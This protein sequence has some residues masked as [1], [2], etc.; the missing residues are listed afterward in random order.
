MKIR[1]ASF[2]TALILLVAPMPAANAA[3]AWDAGHTSMGFL[4]SWL[5]INISNEHGRPAMWTKG[6][7]DGSVNNWCDDQQRRTWPGTLRVAQDLYSWF[8]PPNGGVGWWI[9]CNRGPWAV[10]DV[11]THEW[12]T[13]FAWGAR[14]CNS[15]F[16]YGEGFTEI[17]WGGRWHGAGVGIQTN[18]WVTVF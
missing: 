12:N 4:C 15:N 11:I 8:N 3:I 1:A 17:L 16:Y 7:V 6:T 14:P 18:G 9:L 2:L 10:N 13:G 5:V